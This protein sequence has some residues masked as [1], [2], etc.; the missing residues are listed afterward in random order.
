[1][2]TKTATL[3]YELTDPARPDQY[4]YLS[5]VMVDDRE[6]G[7]FVFTDRARETAYMAHRIWLENADGVQFIKNRAHGLPM[8]VDTTEFVWI[9]L[10]SRPLHMA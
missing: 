1:M 2:T 6:K 10:R 3:Y 8:H 4:R 5:T 9:K 7:G